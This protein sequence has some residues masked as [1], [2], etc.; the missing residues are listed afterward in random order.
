[1]LTPLARHVIPRTRF[2]KRSKAA[3][4]IAR[5]ASR[6][7]KAESE[8]LPSCGRATALFDSFTLSFSVMNRVVLPI[9]R[10]RSKTIAALRGRLIPAPLQNL[11]YRLLDESI[12]HCRDAKPSHLAVR[13]RDFQLNRIYDSGS[14]D[15]NR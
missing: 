6:F 15:S 3:G 12:Q 14:N 5:F 13:L 1:M 7:R 2:L 4:A 10:W 9:T 11:H 8:K